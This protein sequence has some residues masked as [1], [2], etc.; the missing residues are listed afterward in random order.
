MAEYS[1]FSASGRP[2]L[3]MQTLARLFGEISDVIFLVMLILVAKGYTITRG[4]LRR[5]TLIK[6]IVVFILYL[7]AIIVTFLLAEFLYDEGVVAYFYNSGGGIALI[8]V[9]LALGWLW[10]IYAVIFTIKNYPEKR[11]F[12]ILLTIFLSIWFLVSPIIIL[13]SSYAVADHVRQF[14]AFIVQSLISFYGHFIFLVFLTL[15]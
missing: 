5:T 10:F 8:V 6:L 4:K 3:G 14:L 7:V 2:T 13:T 1:Q 11:K 9:R 12:Y 15:N